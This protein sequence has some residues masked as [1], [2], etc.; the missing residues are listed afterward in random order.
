MTK[1]LYI[2]DYESSQWC[3]GQSHCVVWATDADDAVDQASVYMEEEMRELFS[4]EYDDAENEGECCVDDC[5]YA[6]NGVELFDETHE[7]WK[8]FKD[9]SQIQFFPMVNDNA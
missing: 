2:I 7:Y 6:V 5:A 1:Q 4:G 9:E 3:G 8:F